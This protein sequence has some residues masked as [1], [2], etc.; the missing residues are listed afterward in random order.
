MCVT[1]QSY[2]ICLEET[3]PLYSDSII[4]SIERTLV[5]ETALKTISICEKRAVLPHTLNSCLLD[6]SFDPARPLLGKHRE[7]LRHTNKI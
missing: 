2:L 1:I 4:L 7:T 6:F 3:W 5:I